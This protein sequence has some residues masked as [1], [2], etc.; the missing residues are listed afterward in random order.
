MVERGIGHGCFFALNCMRMFSQLEREK[1]V[2]TIVTMSQK[3]G[4]RIAACGRRVAPIGRGD[5]T[6]IGRLRL[7]PPVE[8]KQM[9]F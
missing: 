6:A 7:R 4:R 3:R 1:L 9:M 8:E 5:G 2:R